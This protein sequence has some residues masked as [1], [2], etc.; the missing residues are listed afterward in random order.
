MTKL[1]VKSSI[2]V[3]DINKCVEMIY[4]RFSSVPGFTMRRAKEIVI[5]QAKMVISQ[6]GTLKDLFQYA[7][8]LGY[9]KW[10]FL[11]GRNSRQVALGLYYESSPKEMQSQKTIQYA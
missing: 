3:S 1:E 9:E 4:E 7:D 10:K 8:G 2:K 6:R 5:D 11:R